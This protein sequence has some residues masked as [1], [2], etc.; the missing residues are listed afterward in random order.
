MTTERNDDLIKH[1]MKLKKLKP[2]HTLYL[3][4][5]FSKLQLSS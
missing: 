4:E 3:K 2:T 5:V 1:N